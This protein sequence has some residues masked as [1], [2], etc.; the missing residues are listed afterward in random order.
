[1]NDKPHNTE[2][3]Q[4]YTTHLKY[5]LSKSIGFYSSEFFEEPDGL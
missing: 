3:F 2:N 1:M 5:Y 4:R